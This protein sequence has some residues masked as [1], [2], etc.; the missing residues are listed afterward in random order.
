MRAAAG[1]SQVDV[2]QLGNLLFQ[3]ERTETART[4]DGSRSSARDLAHGA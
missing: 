3:C 1:K 4:S 2:S